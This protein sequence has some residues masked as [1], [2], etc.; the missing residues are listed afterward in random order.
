RKKF[1]ERKAK[2]KL[3][4]LR[5]ANL[6]RHRSLVI[7]KSKFI[8]LNSKISL[9]RS[10]LAF[11]L[12]FKRLHSGA[13]PFEIVRHTG[14]HAGMKSRTLFFTIGADANQ[15]GLAIHQFK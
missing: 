2:S 7:K 6:L 1:G 13:D 15:N 8:Y 9:K 14:V 5:K 12:P 4:T 3:V 10:M 11:L